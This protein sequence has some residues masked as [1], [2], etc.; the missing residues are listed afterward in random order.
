MPRRLFLAFILAAC[1]AVP[2]A[3]QAPAPK[4]L[5]FITIDQ[6]RP[7]YFTRWPGQL[8][9]G[10][11]RLYN[12][13]AVFTNAHQDHAVTET[14]PGH[15]STMSGRFP[16]GT[17]IVSN[18]FGV[19]DPATRLLGTETTGASPARFRGTTLFDWMRAK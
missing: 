10:L 4:L 16:R 11:A 9:G 14:A 7:D 3:A 2:A 18:E 13:G 8:T 15:A 12:G 19:A 6:L 17:G 5:V 1:A